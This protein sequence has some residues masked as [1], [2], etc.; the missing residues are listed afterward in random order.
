MTGK[1]TEKNLKQKQGAARKHG[2]YAIRDRGPAAMTPK[3]RSM[4]AELIEQLETKGGVITALRDQAVDLLVLCGVAQ[5][6]VIEKHQAGKP[7][8]EIKLLTA[9]PRFFNSTSRA[10]KVYLDAMP[11]DSEVLDLAE[12]VTQA[13]NKN[14]DS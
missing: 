6:F 4:R 14:G 2:A 12:H 9:L 10:L 5:S 7:L 11:D 8:D 3:Q 1:L 13:M